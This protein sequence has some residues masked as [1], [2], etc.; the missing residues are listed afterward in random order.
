MIADFLKNRTA[1]GD[2]QLIVT[3]HSPILPDMI[4]DESLYI[5]RK[6]QGRTMIVPFST[7][8]GLWRSN[9]IDKA[10][11]TEEKLC[12]S[13]RILRG[14]FDA[15]DIVNAMNLQRTE[16]MD[17]SFGKFL[18]DLQNKFKEWSKN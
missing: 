3:T 5:C 8:G 17:S 7:P 12:T 11:D 16:Q 13:E 10:L 6:E 18:K 15:E 14:D 2:T 1:T 9:D 4:S